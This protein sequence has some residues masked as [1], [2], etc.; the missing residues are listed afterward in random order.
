[1]KIY[2]NRRPVKG[3][4]GGG[5][6]VLSSIIKECNKRGH[7]LSFEEE[8]H[9]KEKCDLIFCVDPRTISQVSYQNLLDFRKKTSSKIFQRVGDIG[10]HGKPDLT[11]LVCQTVQMSDKA[12]FPSNWA[13][14]SIENILKQKIHS[15]EVITNAPLKEFISQNRIKKDFTGTIKLV[16]H[17]WSNNDKKGFDIYESLDQYCEKMNRKMFDF[18][19]IGRKPESV[20]LKNH[21]P[22]QDIEGLVSIIPEHQIYLTASKQEAGANHVLEALG[23]GL[24]VFYHIDG[25]SINEYCKDYGLSYGSFEE[26]VWNLENKLSDMREL[27]LKM[28]YKRN[29]EKMAEEYVDLF[30]RL[31]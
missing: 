9:T 17:H 10:T 2:I 20:Y 7:E 5:S 24:P 28:C 8:I 26:L 23:L 12:I 27:S 4:W 1:M 19:F 18:T 15:S 6:K 16:S 31:L 29:S 21:V 13:K 25:G 14:D 3:P 11:S 30:E 22:P